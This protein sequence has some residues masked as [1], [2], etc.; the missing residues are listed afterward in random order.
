MKIR[1]ALVKKARSKQKMKRVVIIV[2]SESGPAESG[3]GTSGSRSPQKKSKQTKNGRMKS[4]ADPDSERNRRV[5]VRFA[6]ISM[7]LIVSYVSHAVFQLYLA[8]RR[9]FFPRQRIS[10]LEDMIQGYFSDIVAVNGILNPFVYLFTDTDFRQELMK[11]CGR[12]L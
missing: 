12:R 1:T 5:A 6:I 2:N 9:H 3:P 4:A 10:K 7:F 8:T 11:M